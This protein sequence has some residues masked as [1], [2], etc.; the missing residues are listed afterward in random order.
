MKFHA[1]L[2]VLYDFF[3]SKV[4]LPLQESLILN[5]HLVLLLPA[6]VYALCAGCAPST[7][8]YKVL[9]SSHALIYNF[10]AADDCAKVLAMLDLWW[11]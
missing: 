2:T 10:V 6:A 8:C 1:C 5:E 4:Y 11:L 3:V 7:H 9:L